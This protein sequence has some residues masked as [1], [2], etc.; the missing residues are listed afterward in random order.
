SSATLAAPE[1]HWLVRLRAI[2]VI[3]DVSSSRISVIGGHVS[4]VGN[5]VTPELDLSYFFTPHFSAE[6]ILASS[7]HSPKATNTV[8]GK[9]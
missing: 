3:P 2:D 4:E 7:R 8:L 5:N 6:L 9:V 1:N